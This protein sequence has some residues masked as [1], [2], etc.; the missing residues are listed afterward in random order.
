MSTF[1]NLEIGPIATIKDGKVR[2]EI[3]QDARGGKF[4]SFTGIPY[5]KPP[6]GPLRFKAPVPVDPWPDTLDATKAGN[7]A[8][9]ENFL[10]KLID[11]SEDCLNLNVYTPCLP[12]TNTNKNV[13]KPVMVFIHGGS[14]LSGSNRKDL[15]GPELLISEDIVLVAINYRLGLFG[16]LALDDPSLDVPGNAA[17]KDMVLALKWVQN[18]IKNF[19]GDPN[20]V[21]IF[22]NSAGAASVH[23]LVLSPM[24]KGLFQKALCQSGSALS[25]W[26]YGYKMVDQLTEALNLDKVSDKDLFNYLTNAPAE[27]IFR[28]QNYIDKKTIKCNRHRFIGAVVEPSGYTGQK[29]FS[30]HPVKLLLSGRYNKV[31]MIMGYNSGD[32]MIVDGMV[33]PEKN[34]IYWTDKEFNVPGLLNLEKGSQLSKQLGDEIIRFYFGNGDISRET[35]LKEFYDITTDNSFLRGIFMSVRQH[36]RTSNHPIFMYRLSLESDICFYKQLLDIQLPGVCHVDELGYLFRTILTQI[37]EPNS[38]E[39]LTQR[40]VCRMWTNFAKYGN[41]TPVKDPLLGAIWEPVTK[42][43]HIPFLDIWEDLKV[44]YNPEIERMMFWDKIYSNGVMVSKL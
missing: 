35:H 1:T 40:R 39:D 16:F 10:T 38:I 30:E 25:S 4:Y 14:F 36:C 33:E 6:I 3:C 17:F 37:P 41:P 22:G 26:A 43:N 34:Y 42:S 7:T 24:A 44:E 12:S 23:F 2:G 9:Q 11:G 8:V 31:P 29:F 13:L 27:E 19:L 5:A 32:G 20:N 15:Q 18:N 28:A 21:T